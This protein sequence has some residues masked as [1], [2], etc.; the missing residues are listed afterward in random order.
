MN[1]RPLRKPADKVRA[2]FSGKSKPQEGSTRGKVLRAIQDAEHH[3]ITQL[4]LDALLGART[5]GFVQKLIETGHVE[6][7]A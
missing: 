1:V 5:R 2:T 7:V 6:L 4:D 3:T